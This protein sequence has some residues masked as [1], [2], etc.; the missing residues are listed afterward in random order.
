MDTIDCPWCDHEHQPTG[1]HETDDGEWECENCGETFDVLIE[2]DPMYSTSKS[3]CEDRKHNW[4]DWKP[5]S[6]P[7]NGREIR[8]SY[9]AIC[10]TSRHEIRDAS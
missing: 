10:D 3:E 2:Y 9:C 7:T 6:K 4:L 5:W 1:C 8:F